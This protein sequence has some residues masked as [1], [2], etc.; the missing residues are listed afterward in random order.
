MA[1]I[2]SA[3]QHY[4]SIYRPAGA[5]RYD[6]HKKNQLRA[7]YNNMIKINKE[8][9]L[10]LIKYSENVGCFAID[11]KERTRSIQNIIASF[12]DADGGI[13][14]IFS[15]KIAQSSDEDIISAEYI[16]RDDDIEDN[17]AFNVEVRRLAA[18]QINLGHYLN[19][20]KSDI[21]SGT[22]SFDLSTTL[23]SYEFQ[24]TV[25]ANESN[26]SVQEKLI[27]LINNSKTGLHASYVQNN[28][29]KGAISIRSLQTGH[30]EDERYLFEILPSPDNGSIKAMQLLGIDHVEKL[31]SN[32]AFLLNG[33]E[34]SSQTN[35]FIVNNTFALT[36]KGTNNNGSTT[37]INFKSNADTIADNVLSLVKA[38]NNII[39]L[40]CNYS[41][42]NASGKLRKDIAG[43]ARSYHNELESYGLTI[44]DDGFI[45]ADR[46]LLL[47][48]VTSDD[49]AACFHILNDFKNDLN[50]KAAEVS[51]N[52]MNYVDKILI[53][54]KN[55]AGHNFSAPY[56]SSIYSG[57]ML[58]EFC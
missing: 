55:P 29:G 32:C 24:Y 42:S 34:Q 8:S 33:I 2:D 39:E 6:T 20:D 11:I 22:Y 19:P 14:N 9:P 35:D 12:S 44:T 47:D 15:K 43:V 1:A 40:S 4:L 53:A 50:S 3:Y 27:R 18:P 7:V 58:D 21:R 48:T 57:M 36:L 10:Y 17:P 31:A 23:N 37:S 38:Y 5:T 51:I 16:G 26:R 54:Y 30:D 56:I 28:D 46:T 25:K 45:D 41:D 49:A 52:P 13:E